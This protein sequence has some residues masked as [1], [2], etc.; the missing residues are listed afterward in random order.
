MRSCI[1]LCFHFSALGCWIP[2]FIIFITWGYACQCLGSIFTVSS[3]TTKLV[4]WDHSGINHPCLILCGVKWW[5]ESGRS[6]KVR[7]KFM[8]PALPVRRLFQHPGQSGTCGTYSYGQLCSWELR[9]AASYAGEW[10]WAFRGLGREMS[11]DGMAGS[12]AVRL[13]RVMTWSYEYL[14]ST[15]YRAIC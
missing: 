8:P 6:A 11:G 5:W 10:S 13:A 15:I 2:I 4:R 1:Y 7:R 9:S 3:A 12:M 14:L